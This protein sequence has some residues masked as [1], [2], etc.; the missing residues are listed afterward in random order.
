MEQTARVLHPLF[1]EKIMSA[2]AAAALI[3][4]GDVIGMSG[5]TGSG[6]PKAVPQELAKR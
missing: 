6:Y 3:M 2:E 1:R 5:F 4:P